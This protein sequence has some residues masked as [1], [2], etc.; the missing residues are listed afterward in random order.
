MISLSLVE[1]SKSSLDGEDDHVFLFFT[2]KAVEERRYNIEVSRIA[3]VC[4]SDLGGRRVL[5]DQWTSFLKA[6]L[7]CPFGDAGS[8]TLVQDVFLVHNQSNWKDSIFYATFTSNSKSS[9]C[10]KTA[11]CA[12]KLSDIRQVFGDELLIQ[13]SNEFLDPSTENQ[14]SPYPGSCI[15]NEMRAQGVN[16]SLLVPDKTLQFVRDNHL[17]KGVVTPITG[18]PL[19]VQTEK[20]FSKIVI[21][22]VTSLDGRQHQVMFIGTDSGWLQKAVSFDGEDSRIIEEL[23]LFE[24]PQPV[25]SL[26][27]SLKTGRLYGCS[28]KEAFQINVRD[29]SRYTS[30]DDCLLARD[31]YCGWDQ[32]RGQCASVVGTS[33]GSM[34]QSLDDGDIRICPTSDMKPA[35]VHL[36]LGAAQFLPCSPKTNLP[37][38]WSFSNSIRFPGPQHTVLSQG[39]IIRP[40]F[41]DAGLY[42]CETR[43][44][45]K[46]KVHRKTVIQYTVQIQDN[47]STVMNLKVAVITLAAYSGL[48]TLLQC[49]FCLIRHKKAKRQNN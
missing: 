12:Y 43:E 39:L 49:S 37:V 2:E 10:S 24:T 36:S 31:P 4:K 25:N 32:I 16:T 35:I 34:I 21:D 41:S 38:S 6:R 20:R 8:H 11:V 5:V 18:K 9:G 33:N 27:L 29:C 28:N 42:T 26:K 44:T 3:R 7:D 40:S 19:L 22:Q 30:C 13:S 17:M 14:P 46:G 15:N 23:Q 1:V 48:V 47:N 45:V